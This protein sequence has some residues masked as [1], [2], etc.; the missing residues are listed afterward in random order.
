MLVV[1]IWLFIIGAVIVLIVSS[2]MA[3]LT[4]TNEEWM[5]AAGKLKLSF[6]KANG[7]LDTPR[8]S[9]FVDEFPVRVHVQLEKK[10]GQVVPCTVY[11]VSLPKGSNAE[12]FLDK[13]E[14]GVE[15]KIDQLRSGH[16]LID[17]LLAAN[18][19]DKEKVKGLLERARSELIGRFARM[20]PGIII[21]ENEIRCKF[22]D[23]DSSAGVIRSRIEQ[24]V[25]LAKGLTGENVDVK[26]VAAS[27]QA[28][29][30]A[31][32]RIEAPAKAQ[33][34]ERH[35]AP[36]APSST[37][38]PS[39]Q[40]PAHSLK[41]APSSMPSLAK[42]PSMS[43]TPGAF[44]PA[45]ASHTPSMSATPGAFHPAPASQAPRPSSIPTALKEQPAPA[46]AAPPQKAKEEAICGTGKEEL[47]KALFSASLPGPAEKA[48]FESVKGKEVSWTGV[49]KSSNEYGVDFDFGGGEGTKAI[50]EI[51]EI[52]GSFS[53]KT[54]VKA[55]VQL[56]KGMG[57]ELKAKCG[58]T[59]SFSGTLL[60]FEAFA[61]EIYLTGGK[62][63]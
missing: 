5:Q 28:D 59:V 27:V 29:A 63:S 7:L 53:M 22:D 23:M 13:L 60:K 52:T 46:I 50:F 9:G 26:A 44:H 10:G 16:P 61:K 3:A 36:K 54:K 57:A 47:A 25:Q 1:L 48:A 21:S 56:P 62:L 42:A 31:P 43:A 37:Q 19:Y 34:P 40:V 41:P 8:I 14:S 4:K 38:V 24:L 20:Y 55:A 12:G 33:S 58:Q 11:S 49:L 39:A 32:A 51:C 45:P 17:K 35:E 30:T 18:G 2:K 6:F 15:G